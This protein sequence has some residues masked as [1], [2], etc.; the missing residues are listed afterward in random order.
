MTKGRSFLFVLVFCF[1]G[2][3]KSFLSSL[4]STVKHNFFMLG[5]I[6]NLFLYTYILAEDDAVIPVQA[7]T[8]KDYG[9]G[10]ISVSSIRMHSTVQLPCVTARWTTSACRL[11]G[12][13]FLNHNFS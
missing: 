1:P 8:Q 4:Y 11:C 13:A 7:V 12:F 5:Q 2:V 9:Q 3:F 6:G 10:N